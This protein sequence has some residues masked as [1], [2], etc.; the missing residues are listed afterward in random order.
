MQQETV[1]DTEFYNSKAKEIIITYQLTF[2]FLIIEKISREYRFQI[3]LGDVTKIFYYALFFYD[4]QVS[5]FVIEKG[6]M[7]DALAL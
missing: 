2:Y 1:K 4:R 6:Q 5:I 7:T 3:Q